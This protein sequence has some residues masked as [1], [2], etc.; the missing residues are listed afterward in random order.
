[1]TN[2]ISLIVRLILT[3]FFGAAMVAMLLVAA[4]INIPVFIITMLTDRQHLQRLTAIYRSSAKF[5]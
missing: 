1:M 2:V 5:D 4:I 3:A